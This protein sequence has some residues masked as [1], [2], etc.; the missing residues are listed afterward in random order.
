MKSCDK[1]QNYIWG[2]DVTH[3]PDVCLKCVY[4]DG[5]NGKEPSNWK[6]K[7]MTNADRIRAMGDEQ[8]ANAMIQMTDLDCQIGFCKELAECEALLETEDGIPTSKC[9]KCLLDWLRKSA[10]EEKTE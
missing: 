3:I 1:C 9:E 2:D 6:S 4:I 8:L 5:V 10:T 7:P